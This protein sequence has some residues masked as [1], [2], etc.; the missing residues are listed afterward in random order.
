MYPSLDNEIFSRIGR[1]FDV[2]WV[3]L[4][5]SYPDWM[6]AQK[7]A[8]ICEQKRMVGSERL[9]KKMSQKWR[10]DWVCPISRAA[11]RFCALYRAR[12]YYAFPA[13]KEHLSRL[14]KIR[15]SR[16]NPSENWDI[17]LPICVPHFERTFREFITDN[18][19]D[20]RQENI[21]ELKMSF[22]IV[23]RLIPAPGLC[24]A[25]RQVRKRITYSLAL[26]HGSYTYRLR[27]Y[28]EWSEAE[29]RIQLRW[30]KPRAN[31]YG[32]SIEQWGWSC[33]PIIHDEWWLFANQIEYWQA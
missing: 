31:S 11:C 5:I 3:L 13:C 10:E 23:L 6:E 19:E 18:L 21:A 26:T 25:Q 4:A 20:I 9:W 30:A 8:I 27:L 24:M 22:F 16:L 2:I 7:C 32:D 33:A 12:H 15:T 17:R 14:R 28:P 1:K 29:F